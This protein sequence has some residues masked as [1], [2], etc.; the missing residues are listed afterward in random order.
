MKETQLL[1]LIINKPGNGVFLQFGHSIICVTNTK[2]F[3]SSLTFWWIY[4]F[5]YLSGVRSVDHCRSICTLN[6]SQ[7]ASKVKQNIMANR[8]G[9]INLN[10]LNLN[11]TYIIW[12]WRLNKIQI[13]DTPTVNWDMYVPVY[14][15]TF[16]YPQFISG[17]SV[18]D[19]DF[20]HA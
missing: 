1:W 9:V 6:H 18:C 7:E 11:H 14:I 10:D 5:A 4:W 17:I 2:Y 16:C 8:Y 19:E 12:I 13:I 20:S 3:S 15:Y